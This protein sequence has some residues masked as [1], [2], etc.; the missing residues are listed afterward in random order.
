M[1]TTKAI[2]WAVIKSTWLDCWSE[3]D[4]S[5]VECFEN[6]RQAEV[7]ARERTQETGR[8]H[9]VFAMKPTK[10]FSPKTR[11]CEVVVDGVE[12]RDL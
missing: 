5:P 7:W 3:T 8:G 12:E 11:I 2:R 4:I 6:R 1:A 10:E 9:I